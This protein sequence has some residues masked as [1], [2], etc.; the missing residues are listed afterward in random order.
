[1]QNSLALFIKFSCFH[2]E[3]RFWKDHGVSLRETVIFMSYAYPTPAGVLC[4]AAVND[5]GH[6]VPVLLTLIKQI[7]EII[8]IIE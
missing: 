6:S 2:V 7:S 8:E 5:G 1:M 3:K 4:V